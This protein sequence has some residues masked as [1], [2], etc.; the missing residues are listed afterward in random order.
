MTDAEIEAAHVGA[1]TPFATS[2][3]I[4]ASNPEWPHLFDRE[5]ARIHAALGNR[6][7]LLEHVGSTSV[8]DLAAKPIIDILLGVIDSSD[9]PAYAADLESAGYVL[10][11]REPDWHEHRMFNGPETDIHL[12][13]FSSSC[14]VVRRTLLFRDWLRR[15]SPDRKLYEDTKRELAL[16]NWK[17]MQNYTD[18]KT[19]VIDAILVRAEAWF[20]GGS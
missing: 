12:H 13:V 8:P 4:V 17:Y 6:V 18:A 20:R 9:E 15:N 1:V 2:I 7:L 3:Q 10:K 16:L 14:S 11:I 19:S 5:A